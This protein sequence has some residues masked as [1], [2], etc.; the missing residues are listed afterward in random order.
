MTTILEVHYGKKKKWHLM[1]TVVRDPD[2]A[3]WAESDRIQIGRRRGQVTAGRWG[4]DGRD[5]RRVGC[6]CGRS[7]LFNSQHA[8]A[9]IDAGKSVIVV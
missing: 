2:G 4:I 5:M 3:L 8:L 7:Y 6:G 1:A 9:A